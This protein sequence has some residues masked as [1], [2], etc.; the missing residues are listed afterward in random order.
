VVDVPAT[1]VVNYD[2]TKWRS[3]PRAIEHAARQKF[4]EILERAQP[5]YL[6][7]TLHRGIIHH[8]KEDVIKDKE[9]ELKKRHEDS[10]EMIERTHTLL[11]YCHSLSNW[12]EKA[13]AR[14]MLDRVILLHDVWEKHIHCTP[15]GKTLLLSP[16]NN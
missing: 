6:C 14:W 3:Q 2:I 15:D 9:A 5:I 4:R 10:I 7:D 1:R 12:F 8:F 16:L 11:G 13:D